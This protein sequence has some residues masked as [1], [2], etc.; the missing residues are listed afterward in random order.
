MWLSKASLEIW[1]MCAA[2]TMIADPISENV[3]EGVLPGLLP[4]LCHER[5]GPVDGCL[6][7]CRPT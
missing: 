3:A 7:P 6:G 4:L 2:Q 1:G 5:Y